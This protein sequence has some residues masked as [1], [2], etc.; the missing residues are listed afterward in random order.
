MVAPARSHSPPAAQAGR[1]AEEPPTSYRFRT[2][3]RED[4]QVMWRL[5]KENGVLEP[6]SPYCYILLADH[7]SDTC[8]MVDGPHGPVGFVAGYVP[9]KMPDTV[10]VW[11]IGIAPSERGAGL[12]SKLLDA[13]LDAPG[14]A[15]VRFV[16]ATVTPSNTASEKLFQA[17]ARRHGAPCEVPDTF[18]ED[19]F[20]GANHEAE[21]VFRIGPL[22]RQNR[23]EIAVETFEKHESNVR[24]YC[25]S[26]PT[27]FT[28]AKDHRLW[29]DVGREYVDFF[30][31]AGALNYGHNN[32]KLKRAVIDYME[33]D[34]V[35]HSL[36]MATEAKGRFLERFNEVILQPRGLEYKIMFPGPTGTNAVEAAL[37]LARKVKGREGIIS[38]TNAFHGMTLGSLAITGNAFKR[39]GA[40]VS[41][42]HATVMPF[43]RYVDD[44]FQ[45][46]DFMDQ[47][48]RDGGSG[49]DV[50]A[51]AIVECVQGEGGLNAARMS[52][53]KRLAEICTEHDI[54]L[55]VDDIQAGC[56]RTG[57]FFSFEPAGIEPDI[58][59]LSKS[60]G[61]IGLP[62]AITLMK[63][64]HDVFAPGEHNGTFRG[65]NLAFVAA[66]AAL[67]YWTDDKLSKEVQA[68]SEKIRRAIEDLIERH[69]GLEA[70]HRGRGFMQGFA[71]SDPELAGKICAEAFKNGLIME[72]SGP[73]SEVVKIMP[74]LT[75]DD[76]GLE[77]GLKILARAVETVVPASDKRPTTD[78]A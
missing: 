64:E 17:F 68:K 56:G 58:I 2:P 70:E 31:G 14:C 43:D 42:N 33:G 7:F 6:N 36:D 44:D 60:I 13:L 11:Q 30:A 34:G 54:L 71:T 35:L 78:A 59:C 41:L 63:P 23:E 72:T 18:G 49:V 74:P 38:F 45:S 27:V 21:R 24:S 28:K 3:G 26:F 73:D 62:F 5:V 65:H 9:P 20:P 47:M 69:P 48:L 76:I 61:G 25:R 32:A 46:L 29:D 12:G 39:A 19:L 53:L 67:D 4:G 8:V 66:T 10:F 75:I 51:A 16:L 40:G 37:K 1:E 77:K 15:E 22:A 55:I 50:P 52:W 57:T